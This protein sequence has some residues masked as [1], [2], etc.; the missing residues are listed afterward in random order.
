MAKKLKPIHRPTLLD[1]GSERP[2]L[3]GPKLERYGA[4][5]RMFGTP[6]K[7]VKPIVRPAMREE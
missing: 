7:H 2:H 5:P 4:V 3:R 1:E 6:P